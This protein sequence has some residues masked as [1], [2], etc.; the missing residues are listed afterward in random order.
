ML[1]PGAADELAV[2]GGDRPHLA[3]PVRAA[4]GDRLG[5]T[6]ELAGEFRGADLTVEGD[7]GLGRGPLPV[8]AQECAVEGHGPAFAE[9]QLPGQVA[10]DLLVG[11][12]DGV[13]GEHVGQVRRLDHPDRGPRHDEPQVVRRP[14]WRQCPDVLGQAGIGLLEATA[15][16]QDLVGV[17]VAAQEVLIPGVEHREVEQD[18]LHP[19]AWPVPG[20]PG[21]SPGSGRPSWIR[22]SRADVLTVAIRS[23]TSTRPQ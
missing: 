14:L 20:G 19:G 7:R 17:A 2:P 22:R 15:H 5:G 13:A 6:D 23:S 10:G 18:L 8:P 12:D 1:V 16:E 9:V 4:L 21:G 3:P 11:H